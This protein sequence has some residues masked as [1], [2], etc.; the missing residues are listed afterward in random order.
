MLL[1]AL[2]ACVVVERLLTG[3]L[4]LLLLLLL[5]VVLIL[6]TELWW[7]PA[8]EYRS[9]R[10]L[11]PL[12]L[13]GVEAIDLAFGLGVKLVLALN[14]PLTLRAKLELMNEV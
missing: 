6:V 10:K 5:V 14:L 3:L 12:L 8:N 11:R 13:R 4:L 1:E 9:P 7:K 2:I